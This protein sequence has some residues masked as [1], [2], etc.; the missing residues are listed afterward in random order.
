MQWQ[1]LTGPSGRDTINT[2]EARRSREKGCKTMRTHDIII[3]IYQTRKMGD[4]TK[5][6]PEQLDQFGAAAGV[7]HLSSRPEGPTLA[8]RLSDGWGVDYE[9]HGRKS[10][11]IALPDGVEAGP[12]KIANVT[13]DGLHSTAHKASDGMGRA[14]YCYTRE[15]RLMEPDEDRS[16]AIDRAIKSG[17][18][19]LV[20]GPDGQRHEVQTQVLA[21]SDLYDDHAPE[22]WTG[23]N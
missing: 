11:K 2:T 18:L 17:V 10:V 22:S 1:I 6:G 13:L 21:V 7:S 12:Y 23:S 16:A 3:A 8:D 5:F 4:K 15:A 14:V 19:L 9:T 20:P